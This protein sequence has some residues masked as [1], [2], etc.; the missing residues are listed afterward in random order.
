MDGEIV[1]CFYVEP[2]SGVDRDALTQRIK[3]AF[4]GRTM[5]AWNPGS[6][7]NPGSSSSGPRGNP[8]VQFFTAL[9][10][11]IKSQSQPAAGNAVETPATAAPAA[12]AENSP[13]VVEAKAASAAR[14][15]SA[16]EVRSAEDWN[17]EFDR[18]L[19]DLDIFLLLMTGIGVTIAILSII[20]TMLMSVTERFIEFGILKANGWSN[21][22]V[23][24]LV[25]LESACLGLAGGLLGATL[26]WVAT[27]II[28][29]SFPT[30]INLYAGGEL[31]LFAI[32]FSTGLGILG[33]LYPAIWAARMMPMDA[34][35][36][37]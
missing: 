2:K 22:D 12:K 34:I 30:R 6:I 21:R 28:N 24:Q 9:D 5:A 11:L 36:R 37:G 7:L 27:Q 32:A 13:A 35:R 10:R 4:K 19:A 23:L 8:V 1:S 20:N 25:T 3:N 17:A 26:G 14:A 16:V 31:L 29:A 18:F 15:V 33:G